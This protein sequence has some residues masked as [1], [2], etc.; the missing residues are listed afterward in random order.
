MTC[1]ASGSRARK[2]VGVTAGAS[3][4]EVRVQ[5][6]VEQ[7]RSWGAELPASLPAARNT[8][9]SVCQKRCAPDACGRP[10]AGAYRAPVHAT[11]G[12]TG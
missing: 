10:P 8:W 9:S 2:P 12:L 7:L 5:Q 4:P 11:A 1:S 3:A 6:V